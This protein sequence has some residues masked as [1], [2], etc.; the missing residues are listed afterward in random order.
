M[1]KI[2]PE[3]IP[4]HQAVDDYINST[5]AFAQPILRYLREVVHEAAPGVVEAIKWSR[6]F[7]VYKG[8]ILGNISA[9][10]QHCRFGLWGAAITS[11]NPAETGGKGSLGNITG[12]GD[13]PPRRKL[14][15]SVRAAAKAIDEGERTRAWSRPK[16]AR[17][18]VEIPAELAAALQKNKPAAKIFASK[19][20]GYRR[21]Y[22]EWIADAKRPETRLKR[23]ATSVE[24][25]A[26]GKNRNW[27]YESA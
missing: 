14:I 6:P 23:V 11:E 9:F 7:F 25:I 3:T 26:E 15:S 17:P 10:K 20:P 12:I 5:A 22:C 8:V 18:E 21:E 27:K 4:T 1:V 13:L 16:V 19:G 24:W 2:A